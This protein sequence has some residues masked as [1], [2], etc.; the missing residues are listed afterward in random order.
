MATVRSWLFPVL[1]LSVRFQVGAGLTHSRGRMLVEV[2]AS[3]EQAV[4]V[5]GSA[6]RA[7]RVLAPVSE[8]PG[9][10]IA[11]GEARTC[12]LPTRLRSGGMYT[13][14]VRAHREPQT[15]T[16]LTT[17]GRHHVH[18][19][20]PDSPAARGGRRGP[21]V[22]PTDPGKPHGDRPL[23]TCPNPLPH[24]GRREREEGR[25]QCGKSDSCNPGDR[26]SVV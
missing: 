18:C 13:G 1:P 14:D 11:A 16:S 24:K 23:D 3:Q 22:R 26:K 25:S 4:N 15:P 8:A 5:A 21:N 12:T 10:Q 6:S 7:I 9:A 2:M 17:P 20:A 19:G